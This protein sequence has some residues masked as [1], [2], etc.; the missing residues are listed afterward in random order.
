MLD[1]AFWDAKYQENKTGWDIG[2]ASTPLKSY[3]DQIT[4]K[5]INILIPGAGNS[6]EAQY[7]WENGFRNV[8]VIDISSSPLQ[9]LKDRVPGFPDNQ[10]VKSDF[11]NY[12]FDQKFDLVVEQTFFCAITPNLR[13]P[14]VQKCASE[15]LRPG[16]KMVGVLFNIPLNWDQPP[17]GGKKEDYLPIFKKYL[18]VMVFEDCYNSISPR[19]GSELFINCLKNK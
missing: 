13:E 1:Q 15:I 2:Y 8:W 14:Y 4:D 6:Y 7:L 9:N 16:G 5:S 12:E 17:F 11:F 19:Q 10:L 18:D 3:F